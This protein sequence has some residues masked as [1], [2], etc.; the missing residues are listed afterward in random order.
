M[1]LSLARWVPGVRTV[2]V[3]MLVAL[4]VLHVIHGEAITR[5]FPWWPDGLPGRP[6]WA[7]VGGAWIAVLGALAVLRIRPRTTTALLALPIL[8]AVL[9]LAV[10]RAWPTN[11]FG[12]AWLNV[13]KWLSMVTGIALFATTF[14]AGNRV[15]W[16]NA[17]IR[18]FAA[19]AKW[20]FAAFL[21]GAAIL[22]FRFAAPIAEYYIP[23][24]LPWRLFWMYFTTVT[25][26]AGGIGVLLPATARPAGLLSALMIFLWCPLIHIP[27]T[28]AE[29]HQPGEWC[30]IFESLAYAA[31]AFQLAVNAREKV[32]R[33]EAAF[34]SSEER[35]VSSE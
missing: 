10:P 4:G 1:P 5:M 18:G 33:R 25:L 14:P 2:F 28:V 26:A 17:A 9:F 15:T 31:I 13:F 30:G 34:G 7:K 32:V 21:V 3:L 24:Y 19:A 20:C 27:R 23:A 35:V 16:W 29:P 6:Y 11:E 22:H 12:D 8:L